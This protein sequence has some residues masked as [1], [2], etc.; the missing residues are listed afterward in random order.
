MVY[1]LNKCHRQLLL[2]KPNKLNSSK[3]DKSKY[4]LEK[5]FF[6]FQL[7][8][9]FVYRFRNSLKW[10]I[11]NLLNKSLEIVVIGKSNYVMKDIR[12]RPRQEINLSRQ[13]NWSVGFFKSSQIMPNF[14]LFFKSETKVGHLRMFI[15]PI[16]NTSEPASQKCLQRS[17]WGSLINIDPFDPCTKESCFGDPKL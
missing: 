13:I 8:T 12:N 16:F 10:G 6:I 11:R 1:T 5:H 14:I 17:W 3:Q 2:W 4:L 7:I 9:L 15:F